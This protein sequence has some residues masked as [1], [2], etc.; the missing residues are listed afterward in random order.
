MYKGQND[1][2]IAWSGQFPFV[3]ICMTLNA[4]GLRI[5][6]Y[7]RFWKE[8]RHSSQEAAVILSDGDTAQANSR[9]SDHS[10]R[11]TFQLWLKGSSRGKVAPLNILGE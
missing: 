2:P 11:N 8:R 5:A 6:N 7:I 9:R 1:L 4:T 10:G 3:C